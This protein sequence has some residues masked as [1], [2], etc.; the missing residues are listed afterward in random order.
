MLKQAMV[1]LF[2]LGAICVASRADACATF[3]EHAGFDGAKLDVGEGG[4]EWIGDWWNDRVSSVEVDAGCTVRVYQHIDFGGAS[5]VISDDT[6]WVGDDWNDLI[7]S[8][9]CSCQ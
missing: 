7:S 1:G 6:A 4:N 5:R 2:A 3:Y 9:V 8:F